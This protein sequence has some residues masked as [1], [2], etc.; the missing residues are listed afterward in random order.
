MAMG[1]K[2]NAGKRARSESDGVRE[3]IAAAL[4]APAGRPSSVI[5]T[6]VV[7][8]VFARS[9]PASSLRIA[10][11]ALRTMRRIVAGRL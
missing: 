7:R 8:V 3:A 6:P 2:G 10:G 4:S 11:G 1:T 9:F 5:D